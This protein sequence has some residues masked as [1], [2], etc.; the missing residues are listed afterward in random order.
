MKGVR[1]EI[2]NNLRGALIWVMGYWENGDWV[3]GGLGKWGRKIIAGTFLISEYPIS[4][5]PIAYYPDIRIT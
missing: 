2:R 5:F 1:W 3:I 4:Q